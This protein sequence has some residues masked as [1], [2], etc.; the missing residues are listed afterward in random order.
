MSDRLSIQD[1]TN[2]LL[3][4][5]PLCFR[6]CEGMSCAVGAFDAEIIGS[7]CT[8]LPPLCQRPVVSHSI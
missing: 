3:P 5:H 7:T 1:K 6:H 2:S 4:P 8:A